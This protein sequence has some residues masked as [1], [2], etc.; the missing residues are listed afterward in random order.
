MQI[1]VKLP[2]GKD[3]LLVVD[4][5]DDVDAIKK[6]VCDQGGLPWSTRLLHQG[7]ILESGH[8][9]SDYGI[10][11]HALIVANANSLGGYE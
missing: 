8:T 2:T 3:L 10:S 9:L 1:C 6:K 5:S 4:R 7:H 11:D